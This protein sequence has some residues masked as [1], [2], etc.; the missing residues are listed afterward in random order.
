MK[1]FIKSPLCWAWGGL[2]TVVYGFLFFMIWKATKMKP[3]PGEWF[4]LPILAL[5]SQVGY[6]LGW[7]LIWR[8]YVAK[9]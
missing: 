7:R 2:L 9:Q 4:W 5:V 6:M 8:M 3:V 1:S